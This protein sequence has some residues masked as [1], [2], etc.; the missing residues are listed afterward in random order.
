[1]AL[2]NFDCPECGHNLE[3]DERGAGFIVKCPECGN[4]LQIPDLPRSRRVGK[5]LTAAAGGAA[6]LLLLAANF[7]FWQQARIY[8]REAA[9]LQRWREENWAAAEQELETQRKE[10]ARLKKTLAEIEIP[11]VRPLAKAATAAMEEAETLAKEVE[12]LS[13]E[14]LENSSSART[15]LL[16]N[17]MNKVVETAKASLPAA[18]I[19]TPAEPGKGIQG[20]IIL[21]PILPGPDG[22][23][24]RENA[25][26]TGIEEDK[27]SVK[28]SGGTATYSLTE[29]HPGV[30][31][32]LP[33]DRLL[34]LP[35]RQ[36]AAEVLRIHQLE[37]ARREE[38]LMQLR[39]A[40]EAHLPA[41]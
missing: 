18:P 6:F 4:P 16:R 38:R 32:F 24:L 22:E 33:V 26:I 9:E 30:A 2:I 3:V 13:R 15:A 31:A 5:I 27:V 20:Q 40:I 34:A 25:E 17:H 29:L 36:W 14:L 41:K 12:K 8:R 21:F 23:K 39:Q 35:R 19:L 28:F 11:D 37:N 10:I 1:M 7:F